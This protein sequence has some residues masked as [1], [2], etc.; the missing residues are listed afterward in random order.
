MGDASVAMIVC[1]RAGFR[2]TVAFSMFV[3]VNSVSIQFNAVVT[4]WT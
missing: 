1:K 3:L 4:C 2:Y